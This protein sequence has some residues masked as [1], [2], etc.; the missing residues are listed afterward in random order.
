MQ[1]TLVDRD[2]KVVGSR[3]MEQLLPDD[4]YR[5]SALWLTNHKGD[6]LLARR[7]F[8]KRNDPGR[9]GPAVSGTVESGETYEDNIYKEARE[10]IGLSGE[11]FVVGP[12]VFNGIGRHKFFVQWFACTLEWP[13]EKFKLQAEEVV[14]VE[15]IAKEKL[16]KQLA[17]DPVKFTAGAAEVW[18][19]FLS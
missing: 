11:I 14:A 5:V 6:I 1:V 16:K 3:A 18:A 4:I 19:E 7:Q 10:E 15:W 8:G 13:A 9:W 12:K 17:K 2:D